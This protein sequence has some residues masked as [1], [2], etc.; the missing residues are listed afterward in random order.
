[1]DDMLQEQLMEAYDK[2][3]KK[4]I[5]AHSLTHSFTRL[6]S[7]SQSQEVSDRISTHYKELLEEREAL[8]V[9][10]SEKEQNLRNVL[11][12]KTQTEQE[13]RKEKQELL[14]VSNNE[15]VWLEGIIFCLPFESL[16]DVAMA[17]VSLL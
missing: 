11:Q 7:S 15:E 16:P 8:I 17:T 2:Q 9:H 1:M 12:E 14:N 13:L 5:H 10:L 3:E 6:Y 4:V